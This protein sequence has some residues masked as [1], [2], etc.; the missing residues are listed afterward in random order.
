MTAFTEHLPRCQYVVWSLDCLLSVVCCVDVLSVVCC[1]PC[2]CGNQLAG[3][4]V[5]LDEGQV[6]MQ[7]GVL[8]LL[9]CNHSLSG[10]LSS[11]LFALCWCVHMLSLVL[12]M[13]CSRRRAVMQN[14]SLL[15]SKI[16]L[17]WQAAS[18]V[19]NCASIVCPFANDLLL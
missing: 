12:P 11:Q 10:T 6:V 15:L 17:V 8:L 7:G 16:F 5:L 14:M 4:D 18:C 13:I 2:C 9:L 1:V 19:V 3:K